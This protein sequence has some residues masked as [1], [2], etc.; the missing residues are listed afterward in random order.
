MRCLVFEPS[1]HGHRF[2]YLRHLVEA[3]AELADEVIV[4]VNRSAPGTA[5]YREHVEPIEPRVTVDSSMPQ[6]E[7]LST[8]DFCRHALT[9]LRTVVRDHRPDHVYVPSA[10]GVAQMLGL[11]RLVGINPFRGGVESECVTLREPFAYPSPTTKRWLFARLSLRAAA[12]APWTV[13]HHIDPLPFEEL[14]RR[15]GRYARRSRLLPEPVETITAMESQEARRRLEI[16]E[17][18]RYIGLAGFLDL[19]KGTD[20]LM[21]AFADAPRRHDDRLLLVGRM[22]DRIRSMLEGEYAS[23]VNDR[24]IIV[25]DRFVSDETFATSLS[26]MDVVAACHPRQIGSSGIVVRA[27]KVGRPLLGSDFGWV[28]RMINRFSL[29]RTCNVRDHDALVA[30]VG[31]SLRDAEEPRLN[32]AARRFLKFHTVSNFAASISQN[33]RE[34]LGRPAADGLRTWQWVNEPLEGADGC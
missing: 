2:S 25:I 28:G 18:G 10:T 34:R 24:R 16:P 15:G 8:I 30:A 17:T 12:L 26:A 32:E 9:A 20:L 3:I 13:V 21:R 31:T 6:G 14:Q 7:G 11:A 22:A 4:T 1:R 33:L 23:L 5:E 19:R 29:G 27:P